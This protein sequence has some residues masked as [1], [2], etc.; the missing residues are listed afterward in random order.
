[1]L[2]GIT[3]RGSVMQKISTTDRASN[4]VVHI[5]INIYGPPDMASK[6]GLHLSKHRVWLQRPDNFDTRCPYLNP[7]KIDFPEL[8]NPD[9]LQEQIQADV[10]DQVV[11]NQISELV[12]ELQADTRR[13]AR[14]DRVAGD[15][16][17][18]PLLPWV[19]SFQ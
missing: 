10:D 11:T 6:V 13:A 4:A 9:E 8:E 7:Q 5:D 15:N 17:K 12:H 19:H 18:T 16:L 3:F 2:Q 14:L 1:M